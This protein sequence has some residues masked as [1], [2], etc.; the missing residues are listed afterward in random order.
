[1]PRLAL[2]FPHSA[3]GGGYKFRVIFEIPNEL[4]LS[5]NKKDCTRM[6]E[7]LNKISLYLT[8]G[9]PLRCFLPSCQKA[10]DGRCIHGS[11]GRFYCS[12]VCADS[13]EKIDLSHVELLQKRTN[14]EAAPP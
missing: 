2:I 7:A 5:P 3:S 10:F 9:A 12:Q 1:M 13:G 6:T 8:A 4:P 11:D 14:R